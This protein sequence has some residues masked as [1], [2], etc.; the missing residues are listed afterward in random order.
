M[1]LL[2]FLGLTGEDDAQAS[3]SR[4]LREIEKRLE[5]FEPAR[6][7]FFAAFAYVLAR[8]A[9]AD[10]RTE[11]DELEEAARLLTL[12]SG[13]GADEAKLVTEIA[14]AQ[15]DALGATHNYSVTREFGRIASHAERLDLIRC[16]FAVA[17]VDDV[18]SGAES[19]EIMNVGREL[20]CSREEVIAI[21]SAYRDKLAELRKLPSE[22]R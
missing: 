11:A 17:A 21:R 15:V 12:Q 8:I 20:G 7:R 2:R 5:G 13:L 19:I 4:A 16:L 18:I 3:D 6:A 10:L 22:A 9:E 1:S 14:A